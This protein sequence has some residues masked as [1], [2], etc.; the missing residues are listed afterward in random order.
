[1]KQLANTYN[2]HEIIII[3]FQIIF[4]IPVVIDAVQVSN[5]CDWGDKELGT[6][7]FIRDSAPDPTGTITFP[8]VC[9]GELLLIELLP[10]LEL[11]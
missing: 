10:V 11:L 5:Q 3:F 9:C 7:P 8:G 4:F 1:M 2:G 6:A